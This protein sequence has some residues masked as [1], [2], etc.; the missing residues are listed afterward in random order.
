LDR[1]QVAG[2]F[3]YLALEPQLNRRQREQVTLQPSPRA[4]GALSTQAAVWV[5][6]EYIKHPELSFD[7]IAA[8]LQEQRQLTLAA[9][10]IQRFFEEHA[11]KKTPEAPT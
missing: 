6:V 4:I 7:Q 11:L 2:Q 1:L 5:L 10:D 3:R 8:E 9:Q